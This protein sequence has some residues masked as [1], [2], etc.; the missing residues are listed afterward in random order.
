MDAQPE[1]AAV[2]IRVKPAPRGPGAAHDAVTA[3]GGGGH[4][5]LC[6]S[7]RGA[8]PALQSGGRLAPAHAGRP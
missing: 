5:R 1:A 6:V 2:G 3:G 4:S 8:L 7:A